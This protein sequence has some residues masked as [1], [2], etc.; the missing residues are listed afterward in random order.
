MFY[1]LF[2]QE[3]ED[4][5]TIRGF[6]FDWPAIGEL[7]RVGIPSMLTNV[8]LNLGFF[9]INNEVEKYGTAVLTGQGIANNITTV[10]F[11][12]PGA[13]GSAVTTMVS[14]NVGAG[15]GDKAR[16]STFW[17]SVLSA[18][19]AVGIIAIVVPLSGSLTVL[20]TK[21]AAVLEMANTALHIY[22]YSVVGFGVC[23]VI[24]GAFIGLGRTKVP[25]LLGLLR[26]W[27]LRYVFILC[28][29]SLLGVYSVYWGNLFSNYAAALIAVV[30]ILPVKWQ[31]AIHR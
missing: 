4:R 19:T 29:E 12:L 2:I 28:T 8:M 6:R 25:L 21:D 9:L 18:I 13:F 20:F 31:S 30:L 17:G 7:V 10:C 23:M 24:Q 5:L 11:N 26:V 27:A 1:E 16:R 15:Q 22:T 3:S 14:M